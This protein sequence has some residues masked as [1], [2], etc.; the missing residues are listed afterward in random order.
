MN[1][2]FV[3]LAG[4]VGIIPALGQLTTFDN[5]SG[6][7]IL[8]AWKLMLWSLGLSFIGVFFA[9]PLR[10][11]AIIKEQLKFPSGT[12]TAQMITLLHDMPEQQLRQRIVSNRIQLQQ[13]EVYELS[14]INE[15][16]L[17][18]SSED[19]SLIV[20]DRIPSDA[21]WSLK[22]NA[23]I[24]SFSLSSVY[25][26]TSYFFPIIYALP[27]FNWMSLNYIDFKAWEWYF[28]PS[29]SYIGQG[30]IMVSI[31]SSLDINEILT[32]NYR[33]CL[34]RFRCFLG[35]LLAG[36]FYHLLHIF[37]AGHQVLLM[38]GKLDQKDGYY[39]YLLVL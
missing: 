17:T 16:S 3:F 33:G 9:V 25:T 12:A 11:Q 34:Q 26:L 36:V 35:L 22:L 32:Y 13:Q 24:I 2:Q 20:D 5:P 10:K 7:I 23:L 1:S 31:F 21:A 19:E 6:P 28:T 38:T 14:S 30:I 39:G 8:P 27:V 4:F 29:L 37:Q 18:T 15:D